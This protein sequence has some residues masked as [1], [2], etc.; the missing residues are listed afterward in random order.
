MT[1]SIRWLLLG[2]LLVA[3]TR[4][5]TGAVGSADRDTITEEEIAA[6]SAINA[7]EIVQKLRGNFLSNRGK[8]TIL[9]KSSPTPMVY[10]DGVRYGEIASLRNVPATTVQSIRLYRAWEAQQ[11]YGNDVM[12]GVIEVTTKK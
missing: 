8:T 3:C 2:L 5:S 11:R 12:G 9:G 6:T 10:V 4:Q 1:R 7:Y